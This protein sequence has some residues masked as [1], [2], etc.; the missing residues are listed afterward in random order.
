MKPEPSK[1][2]PWNERLKW[3]REELGDFRSAKAAAE[4]MAINEKT[5]GAYE[6]G[7]NEP[8]YE[9]MRMFCR[10]FKVSP[11]WVVFG[12]GDPTGKGTSRIPI[13][14]VSGFLEA[15]NWRESI[16][17][18]FDFQKEVPVPLE[19]DIDDRLVYAAEVRGDSMNRLYPDG[20]IL[21]L[22]RRIDGPRDVIPGRHYH[23]ERCDTH[24]MREHTI[25]MADVASDGSIWLVPQS[26]DPRFTSF[27]AEEAGYEVNFVGRVM[28]SVSRDNSSR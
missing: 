6:R 4:A 5:Y 1:T 15:G 18:P 10:R 3:A 24:G 9:D 12:D 19:I 25:K 7:R 22:E 21:I 13:V 28:I 23:V 20:T 16:D 27:P 26:S 17:L 14:R 2:A 11:S 8:S